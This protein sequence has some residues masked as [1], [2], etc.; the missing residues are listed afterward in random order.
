MP[1]P[2]KYAAPPWDIC[3]MIGDFAFLAASSAAT[4]VELDVTLIAG[5]A[6]L[7]FWQYLTEVC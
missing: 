3:R 2:Q 5:M 1:F 4:T 6:K 7:C